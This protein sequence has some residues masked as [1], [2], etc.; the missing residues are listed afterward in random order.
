MWKFVPEAL[1][2][3]IGS[4][5]VMP[6]SSEVHFGIRHGE[7][8]SVDLSIPDLRLLELDD[9]RSFQN[10]FGPVWAE[11]LVYAQLTYNEFFS[12]PD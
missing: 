9:L 5:V 10:A 2:Q 3:A 12:M 11:P 6:G 8:I 1:W 7:R 4:S